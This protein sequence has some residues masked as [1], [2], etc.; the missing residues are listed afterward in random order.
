MEC[1]RCGG[2][3]YT[4]GDDAIDYCNHCGIVEGL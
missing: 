1:K 3:A 2:E 4:T